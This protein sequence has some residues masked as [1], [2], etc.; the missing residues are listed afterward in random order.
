MVC[1]VC[2]CVVSMCVCVDGGGGGECVVD[3]CGEE[4]CGEGVSVSEGGK[5]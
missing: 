1:C 3:V 2:V 4:M 5:K